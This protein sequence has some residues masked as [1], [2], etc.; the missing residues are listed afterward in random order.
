MAQRDRAA[1]DLNFGGST[2]VLV[3]LVYL[4]L[5]SIPGLWHPS[6]W[7]LRTRHKAGLEDLTHV[8]AQLIWPRNRPH[9]YSAASSTDIL[10]S[11]LSP[12]P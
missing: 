10:L 5:H 2:S 7:L 4:N 3:A 8:A 1:A 6:C 9:R 11:D 12:W